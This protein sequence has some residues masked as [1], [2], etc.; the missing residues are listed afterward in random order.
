ML[1]SRMPGPLS[2]RLGC[3]FSQVCCTRQAGSLLPEP[4]GCHLI[5][6]LAGW[7]SVGL[8]HPCPSAYS[9]SGCAQLTPVRRAHQNG[10]RAPVKATFLS[11]RC[12][13]LAL[14]LKEKSS[15]SVSCHS[16][17]ACLLGRGR[18]EGQW[19][20]DCPQAPHQ[21]C[22][23]HRRNLNFS[24]HP[25]GFLN[26]PMSSAENKC[27]VWFPKTFACPDPSPQN[28]IQVFISN[29]PRSLLGPSSHGQRLFGVS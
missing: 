1:G 17:P 22:R 20:Y 2:R 19:L 8:P 4:P 13:L 7:L 14:H 27:Q 10:H 28:R 24:L 9:H 12:L 21:L 18:A 6:C 5:G 29:S 16:P 11:L 25:P 15:P 26:G 23:C 3:V